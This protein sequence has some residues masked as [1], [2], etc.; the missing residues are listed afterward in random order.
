MTSFFRIAVLAA[1]LALAACSGRDAGGGTGGGTGGGSG[2]GAGR[3]DSGTGG[4]GGP[5]TN[6]SGTV[7]T[8]AGVAVATS[9]AAAKANFR[10]S[11]SPVK[12][13]GVVVTAVSFAALS[14][15]TGA[16]CA[17]S[18]TKGAN[19]SFWV[20]DPNAMHTG[21][22][23]SKFRCDPPLDYLPKVG[24]VLDIKGYVGE[25][26]AFDGRA[27]N[28]WVLK[29]QYD[30]IRPAPMNGCVLPA[31]Q[32]LEMTKTGTVAPLPDSVV[33]ATFGDSGAVRASGSY[34]GS[35]VKI[36]APASI[37]D[38]RPLA[39]KRVSAISGDDRYF[40]FQLSNGVYV[41]N[42][43]TFASFQSDGGAL[44]DGGTS[45]CDYRLVVIDGGT[46]NFSS[47]SG[48][49]DSYSYT[50]CADGGTQ[51]T[52]FKNY[53]TVPGLDAGYTFVLYPMSCADL[54]RQ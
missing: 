13:T 9:I 49:W 19:A 7:V 52:C 39:L 1:S 37:S 15:T 6:D 53:G 16:V 20:A 38:P 54:V 25:E 8:D 45:P 35:R 42:D 12:L 4:G 43:F 40:G 46:V 41:S 3:V 50:A 23:V 21:I 51:S 26:K 14:N 2:G 22:Y 31:C 5:M 48:V 24:D 47:I 10:Y 30:F 11:G 28:R 44:E 27:Q 29:Q 17:G 36:A 34:A 18:T 33:D 32:P